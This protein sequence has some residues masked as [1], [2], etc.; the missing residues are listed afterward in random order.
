MQHKVVFKQA[1][2][3]SLKGSIA[4]DKL[5]S[6]VLQCTFFNKDGIPLAERLRIY[7]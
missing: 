3:A 1:I 7:R 6:G 2:D 4:T 5:P